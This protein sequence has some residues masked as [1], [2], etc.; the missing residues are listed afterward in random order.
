[1]KRSETALVLAKIAAIDNRRLDPPDADLGNPMTTPVLSAWHEIIGHLSATDCLQA[2]LRHRQTSTE[3]LMPIHVINLVATVRAERVHGI[4]SETV[5]Q[6]FGIDGDDPHYLAKVQARY[7][8]LA[9]GT[10]E[11][12]REI[13]DG[14]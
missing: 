2:V 1:M 12:P 7:G 8:E 5:A 6:V 4:T 11:R 14:R 10:I 3:W 9:D 13:E